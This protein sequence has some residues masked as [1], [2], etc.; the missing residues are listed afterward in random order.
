MNQEQRGYSDAEV[1]E[2]LR[3]A[4]ERQLKRQSVAGTTKAE[5][6]DVAKEVGVSQADLEAAAN[7]IEAE[8]EGKVA[9]ETF[10]G[11]RK[12][13]RQRQK[14]DFSV[15]L[16]MYVLVI[17]FLFL[18]NMITTGLAVPWALFPALAWGLGL[19]IHGAVFLLGADEDP[20]KIREEMERE[21]YRKRRKKERIE[22]QR[23]RK[24]A[25][26]VFVRGASDFGQA[27]VH[28]AGTLLGALAREINRPGRPSQTPE[29]N[30]TPGLP[31]IGRTRIDPGAVRVEE[32]A[33]VG[34][35]SSRQN[36]SSR[37]R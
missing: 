9:E 35:G 10:E 36:Q 20:D 26:E 19:A 37:N 25:A 17:T 22:E 31:S 24:E 23:R 21:Q 3:R 34:V 6:L 5:L 30:E 13:R 7:E 29:Q 12:R 32:N 18:L 2:I 14:K 27:V 15:H 33:E 1:S 4:L 11:Y 16:S 8:R 28:G